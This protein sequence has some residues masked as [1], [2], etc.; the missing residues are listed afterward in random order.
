MYDNTKEAIFIYTYKTKSRH[1]PEVLRYNSVGYTIESKLKTILK[2]F[3]FLK[4]HR[5]T[6]QISV[7]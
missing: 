2:L 6:N 5:N 1:K 3:E 4:V 7:K